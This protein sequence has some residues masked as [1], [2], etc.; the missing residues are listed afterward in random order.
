MGSALGGDQGMDLVDD[1]GFY[2]AE[3]LG[4]L[5]GE[6]QVKGFRGGDEDVRGLAAEAGSLALG[7]VAGADADGGFVKRDAPTAGHVGDSGQWRAQVTL[8]IHSKSFKGR[9]VNNSAALLCVLRSWMKHEPVEAPEEGSEGFAGTC[10]SQDKGAFAACDDGPAQALGS[11]RGVKDCAEP[12]GGNGVE[13]GEGI[14][15]R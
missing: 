13:A 5:R 11:C 1:D 6:E 3:G 9:D 7:S 15:F 8:H 14:D 12:L 10:G 2:G 4:C